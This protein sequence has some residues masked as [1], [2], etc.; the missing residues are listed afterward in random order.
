MHIETAGHM[1]TN[2]NPSLHK[3]I[4]QIFILNM[5]SDAWTYDGAVSTIQDGNGKINAEKRKDNVMPF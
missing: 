2:G 4:F 5:K 1:I 3:M